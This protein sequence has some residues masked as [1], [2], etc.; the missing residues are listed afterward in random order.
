MTRASLPKL[1]VKTL[2]TAAARKGITVRIVNGEIVAER[3]KDRIAFA[4]PDAAAAF[5]VLCKVL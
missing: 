1:T 5:L 2:A 4:S 3:G